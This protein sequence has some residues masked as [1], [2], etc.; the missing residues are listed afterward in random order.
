M[1]DGLY[2]GKEEDARAAPAHDLA[3][4]CAPFG[5]VTVDGASLAGTFPFAK[6]AVVE[7]DEAI[8]RQRPQL[9]AEHSL[10]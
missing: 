8:L 1:A 2:G 10:A 4:L 9:L 7:A 5:T 6:L 3:Y